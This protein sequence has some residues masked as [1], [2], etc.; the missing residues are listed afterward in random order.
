MLD[1]IS[2]QGKGIPQPSVMG[3]LIGQSYSTYRKI[4]ARM[5]KGWGMSRKGK[6]SA[7]RGKNN[8]A[9]RKE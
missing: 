4:R 2:F 8:P 6:K 9:G 3:W 1:L 7:E 5:G